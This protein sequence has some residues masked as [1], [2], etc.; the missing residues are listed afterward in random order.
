MIALYGPVAGEVMRAQAFAIKRDMERVRGI[1]RLLTFGFQEP[2]I[3]IDFDPFTL[4]TRGIAASSLADQIG[5]WFRD[6]VAGRFMVNEREWLARARGRTED[7]E[8][9][10][11]LPVVIEGVQLPCRNWPRYRSAPSGLIIWFA[12]VASR[13]CCC[14]SPKSGCQYAGFDGT[15][16]GVR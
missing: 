5:A 13:R 16:T 14:Q 11:H 7:P 3:H 15:A 4:A 1:D 2:E 9:V 8:A 12:I 10:A 6:V